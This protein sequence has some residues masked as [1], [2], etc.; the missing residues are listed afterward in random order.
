VI[1]D[2]IYSILSK[3]YKPESA[4]GRK[5]ILIE[6]NDYFTRKKWDSYLTEYG[7]KEKFNV[8]YSSNRFEIYRLIKITDAYFTF[9]LNQYYNLSNLKL[10]YFAASDEYKI[11]NKDLKIF[12]SKGI[13]RD[14]IAEYCLSMSLCLLHGFKTVASNF[15]SR[16]WKQPCFK[17]FGENN[18]SSRIIGIIG[19]GNNGI[20]ICDIFRKNNCKVIGTDIDKSKRSYV[21]E[22]YD[23]IDEVI[24]KADI[25]ILSLN[26]GE[27]TK[28]IIN[29]SRISMM[30]KRTL[31]I[32]ISRGNVINENDLYKSLSRGIIAGAALDV[33]RKEPLSPH[34]KLWKL[35]NLIITPHIAG[36]INMFADEIMTDFMNKLKVS[37]NV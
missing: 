24:S 2:K 4:D 36:N 37:F 18:I 21:D 6:V 22:F 17:K 9:G 5:N 27:G 31:L 11:D 1:K 29:L 30:D 14:A 32:N 23:D 28:G 33:F 34:S 7:I 10:I 16:E 15:Q 20:S 25:L 26:A 12:S 35:D 19:L 8:F 13:S 3:F